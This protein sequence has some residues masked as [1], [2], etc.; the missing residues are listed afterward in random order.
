M[1]VVAKWKEEWRL[2]N[3][4]KIIRT[5]NHAKKI[6]KSLPKHWRPIVTSLKLSKDLNKVS[7]GELVSSLKSHEIEIEN[8]EFKRKSKSVAFK[9]SAR[10]KKTKV[11]QAE[12]DEESEEESKEED[13]LSLL[14]RRVNQL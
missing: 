12:S 13:E 4:R 7:L 5:K 6:I 10:F 11:L 2:I 1:Q 9:S 8:D 3:K 14:S